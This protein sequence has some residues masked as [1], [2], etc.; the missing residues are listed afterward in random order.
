MRKNIIAATVMLLGLLT[1]AVAQNETPIVIERSRV[2]SRYGESEAIQQPLPIQPGVGVVSTADIKRG[3]ASALRFHFVVSAP[4]TT[5]SWGVQILDKKGKRIWSYSGAAAPAADFWSDEIPGEIAKVQVFAVE[6]IPDLKL[7]IDR[8]IISR[9]PTEIRSITVDKL[10]PIY[11]E[12]PV[13]QTWGRSV[14]RLLFVADSDG[15]QYLC[16]GFLVARDLFMTNNHCI[17]SPSEM[18]SGLAQFDYD[19]ANATPVTLRFKQILETNVD[20]DFTLLRLS[21]TLDRT[22]FTFD[23]TVNEPRDMVIIQHPA[24]RPKQVSVANCKVMGAQVAGVS[25]KLTD[26]GHGCD[27]MGGSSGS[28]VLDYRTGQV[29]GLHH[30]GFNVTQKPVNRAVRIQEI[31]DFL[32]KKLTDAPARQALGL[33][34]L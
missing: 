27:T 22:P 24:G 3:D 18:S 1:P 5:A 7:S 20:L 2:L 30:L 12:T 28:P 4:A 11:D 15:Q 9:K 6:E 19:R 21:T 10:K 17:Q 33:P 26:F 16:T 8:L 31:L 23:T 14:A 25:T 29:L 13:I 34:P 32:Q